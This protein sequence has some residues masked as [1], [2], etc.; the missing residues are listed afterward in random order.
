MT[1]P[2]VVRRNLSVNRSSGPLT[3]GEEGL[4][5]PD[6]VLEDV[7]ISSNAFVNGIHR[8]HDSLRPAATSGFITPT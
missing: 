6:E 2:S 7:E 3:F 8:F 5:R 1:R 4:R